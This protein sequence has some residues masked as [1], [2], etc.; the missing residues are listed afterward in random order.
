MTALSSVLVLAALA[1]TSDTVLVQFTSQNCTHCQTM[2]PV[3]ERMA[4]EG[5]PVQAIDVDQQPD[6]ARQFKITGVPTFVALSRGQETGRVVG[7]TSY[8]QLTQLYRG[9]AAG[10]PPLASSAPP[11]AIQPRRNKLLWRPACA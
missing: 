7:A 1:G 11:A 4:A 9:A 2:Q 5:C 3:L 6:V 8:E 10:E